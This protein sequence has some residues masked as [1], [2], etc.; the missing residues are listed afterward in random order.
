MVRSAARRIF[1]TRREK[2]FFT[3]RRGVNCC[4]SPI[5]LQISRRSGTHAPSSSL[6]LPRPPPRA[7]LSGMRGSRYLRIASTAR[8]LRCIALY[9]T[10]QNAN[11]AATRQ[12][13]DFYSGESPRV[14]SPS[15]SSLLLR[16]FFAGRDISL[17]AR[18]FQFSFIG[19]RALSARARVAFVSRDLSRK[20]EDSGPD[21]VGR[22]L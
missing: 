15:P 14:D 16:A 3:A 20:E 19:T 10:R 1:I 9:R 4:A 12:R 21:R 22:W 7:S 17:P 6:T 18:C 11:N 5:L 13:G 8:L 2:I